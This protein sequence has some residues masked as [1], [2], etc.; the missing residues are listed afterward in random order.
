VP[1]G[2]GLGLTRRVCFD[3]AS[4]P[5]TPDP[6]LS[7]SWGVAREGTFH[8]SE[9]AGSGA[10]RT[11]PR[12]SRVTLV[13]VPG[14]TMGLQDGVREVIARPRFLDGHQ[15]SGGQAP[16]GRGSLP[17]PNESGCAIAPSG[18][19]A[20]RQRGGRECHRRPAAHEAG[21]ETL[22]RA[23]RG[24]D[25]RPVGDLLARPG[26]NLI[27]NRLRATPLR[28]SSVAVTRGTVLLC[29]SGLDDPADNLASAPLGTT[30][31]M[32]QRDIVP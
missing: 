8:P 2:W 7:G 17:E 20:A 13:G 11:A 14:L 27:R 29:E 23:R 19:Q 3:A 5:T 22:G 18:P 6:R 25:A 24:S 10:C 28:Q 16:G 4:C 15:R 31:A 1:P 21:G 30:F 26:G 12:E 9:D 32:H